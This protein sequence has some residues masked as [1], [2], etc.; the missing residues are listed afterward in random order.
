[1][2]IFNVKD[3]INYVLTAHNH[4]NIHRIR[5]LFFWLVLVLLKCLLP[6]AWYHTTL[7]SPKFLLSP[8]IPFL[9]DAYSLF[10]ALFPPKTVSLRKV[11]SKIISFLNNLFTQQ[12]F[13]APE[14]YPLTT[15]MFTRF[16]LL[17]QVN[18]CKITCILQ[19]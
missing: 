2:I 12:W 5:G 7:L 15:V 13:K 1:M 3:F 18:I 9:S 16:W 4:T 17:R 8:P 6:H 10:Q 19:Y 11:A 14:S